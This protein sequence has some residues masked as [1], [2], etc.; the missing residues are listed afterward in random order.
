MIMGLLRGIKNFFIFIVRQIFIFSLRV[1]LF[2]GLILGIAYGVYSYKEAGRL[3]KLRK[4]YR[5]VEIDM[6][7]KLT[8][9]EDSVLGSF[10]GESRDYFKFLE[11]LKVVAEDKKIEGVIFK[12]DSF[13]ANRVQNEEMGNLI[14]R[15]FKEKKTVA[16][17][18]GFDRNSYSF[19]TYSKAIV[20]PPT[21]SSNSNIFPYSTEIPF[22]KNLSDKLGVKFSVIN[23]GN[24]KAM[25]ENLVSTSMSRYNRENTTELLNDIYGNFLE[26]V[27]KNRTLEK[28]KLAQTLENGDLVLASPFTMKE[29]GM[30]DETAF[31]YNFKESLGKDAVIDMEEYIKIK[32]LKRKELEE[33]IAV[34]FLAGEITDAPMEGRG[35]IT[36][37]A[38]I[39]LVQKALDD[40]KV[41]GILLR[42]DSPGGSA[43]ASERIYNM[44][45]TSE[46]RK[47]VYVS[48]G[49]VAASGG[50]YIASAGDKIYLNRDTLTGSIGVVSII[51]N[52]QNTAD[53]IGVNLETIQKGK[54]SNIYSV[55]QPMEKERFEL[56]L[57]SNE[58]VY[59]EFKE[60]VAA[61]RG[62]TLEEVEAVAQGRVWVGERAVEKR[63]AD[64]IATLDET[65]ALLAKEL[66]LEK[67]TA[68]KIT[69]E[70]LEGELFG[71]LKI[72]KGFSRMNLFMEK[73]MKL[74][75]GDL[76]SLKETVTDNSAN[77]YKPLFYYHEKNI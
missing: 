15:I 63:L 13:S 12:L 14:K 46:K 26:T 55:F 60:R 17:S 47:P 10:M 39:K 6:S 67:F 4:E 36:P 70:D 34:I 59:A 61:G 49:S 42:I 32:K 25:G 29:Y 18:T 8:E 27:S 11:N 40:E 38:A 73:V 19:A 45:K 31:Y 54:N 20:M 53:M 75:L 50:Y 62:L 5:Y 71:Y 30:I 44:L 7:R 58:K 21:E 77:Y 64:G 66:K 72:F 24:Y 1:L 16:Y 56:L 65:I 68:E 9:D 69:S 74:Q 57:K 76:D 48:M 3:E 22:F 2:V 43:L 33:K 37:D 52:F 23:I 41:K 35:G 51:P 28:E